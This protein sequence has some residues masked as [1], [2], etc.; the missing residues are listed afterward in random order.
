M[1]T[2]RKG[3]TLAA[4]H[5]VIRKES[6]LKVYGSAILFS[7]IVGFSFLG[8]KTCV[9]LATPLET[10]TFRFN[11]AFLATLI[12][13]LVGLVKINLRGKPK[14]KLAL[15]AGLYLGFMV[16]QTIAL[17]FSTSIESGIIFAIIPILA[18]IIASVFLKESTNWKQNIFVCMSVA[19]VITMFVLGASDL[20]VNIVGL[21]ILLLSSVSMACSNVMMR[22]VRGVYKPFEISFFITGGGCIIFN[23]AT[24]IFGIKNGTLGDYFEPLSHMNFVL[25]TAYLGIPSTLISAL[26]MAYMLA[27]MEAVKA[28][29]FGN[30]STAISIVAG[31]IVLGEQLQLYHI[32]CTILIIMGVIGLSLPFMAIKKE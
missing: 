27:H 14:K 29:I 25:A 11:F 20:S 24:I 2:N 4:D 32:A 9:S 12:T 21:V 30:L 7:L 26:F 6:S 8:V 23:L 3:K 5:A 16:L 10:L 22:Y 13:V 15:T 17:V 28:T 19:A 1:S 18:K 31:V